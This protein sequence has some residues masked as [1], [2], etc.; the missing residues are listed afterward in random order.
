[1]NYSYEEK[2]R[3]VLSVINDHRSYRSVAA[4]I[5]SEQKHIRRWVA[6]YNAHG[7]KVYCTTII[8]T[9]ENLSYL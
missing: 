4:E 7:E 2:L 8:L 6:L 1:M 5:G 9:L 3:S